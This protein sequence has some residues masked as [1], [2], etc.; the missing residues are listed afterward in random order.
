ME[1]AARRFG[2]PP[3]D[4]DGPGALADLRASVDRVSPPAASTPLRA[5][6]SLADDAGRQIASRLQDM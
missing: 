5:I 6:E 4:L 3:A 2:E 1:E